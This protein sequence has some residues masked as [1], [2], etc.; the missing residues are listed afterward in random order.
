MEKKIVFTLLFL[1]ILL[2][3]RGEPIDINS[4]YG[5]KMLTIPL[6]PSVSAMAGTGVMTSKEAGTF[7]ETPTA[8]LL[9]EINSI[10]ITQNLWI[11]DTQMNSIAI[12]TSS[13]VS[14]FGFALR[15]L[16][17]GK[18]DAR[19]IT[20][21]VI[22]EFHPLD[23]NLIVNYARRVTPNY[24]A[25]INLMF[26]Y[27]KIQ[28]KSSTGI[29][30]DLGV[31]YLPPVKG[32]TLN[33]AIK[34]IG[35]TTKVDRERIKVPVTP[36]LSF[37]YDLPFEPAEIGTEAKILKHP[38]DK[39][40][41]VRLGTNIRIYRVFNLRAGYHLNHDTQSYTAGIGLQLNKLDVNYAY[42]PFDD[43]ISDAHCFGITYKF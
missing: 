39:N 37:S 35:T 24:Y 29:A 9:G 12:N 14:S 33:A 19:D 21:E 13:G 34:H 11:F 10:S 32:L 31:S 43:E 22:G 16:D 25:G 4:L 28:T 2:S 23:L 17:Y 38:D 6:S 42:L 3:L 26:L 41:R 18:L 36:E 7:I 1:V 5:W 20:G 30:A 40:V 8:G 15:S 27:Q